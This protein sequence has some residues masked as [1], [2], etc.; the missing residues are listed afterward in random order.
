[1]TVVSFASVKGAPG[2]TTL[3]CLVGATWPEERQVMVVEFDPSGGDLAARFGLS[4]RCGWSTFAAST[5]RDASS[6]LIAPHL[7]RLPGGLDVLVGTR[8]SD[9]PAVEGPEV[10]LVS[11]IWDT[12]PAGW[13]ALVDLGRLQ[14]AGHDASRWLD[15]SD[16]VVVVS[17]SD[18]ASV[19]Q[20]RE[21][22][23]SLL[24]RCEHRIGLVVVGSGSYSGME[25][26]R[27][28][29][30]PLL[31]EIPFEP[32]AAAVASGEKGGGRRLSRSLLTVSAA[33]LAGTLV[34]RVEARLGSGDP[35]RPSSQPHGSGRDRP[36]LSVGNTADSIPRVPAMS[37]EPSTSSEARSTSHLQRAAR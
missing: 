28:T 31:G 22:A 9:L 36:V 3:A 26:E 29:A 33:R 13:D 19:V 2:V 35:V 37:I 20:L 8:A 27:F 10:A 1:M 17:R 23:A 4:S 16:A 14:P 12:R 15:R 7:Q 11:D 25:I 32:V 6:A 34:R 24:T 21:R 18:A 5:R 30:I